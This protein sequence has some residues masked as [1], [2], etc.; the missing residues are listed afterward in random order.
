MF[1]RLF[2]RNG[3]K[4]GYDGLTH[5]FPTGLT[6]WQVWVA[7]G[8]NEYSQRDKLNLYACFQIYMIRSRGIDQMLLY[9]GGFKPNMLL[10]DP[11]KMFLGGYNQ[12]L[13]I[14]RIVSSA[15]NISCNKSSEL[16]DLIAKMGQV[17]RSY[18]SIKGIL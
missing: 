17:T 4:Y 1:S 6:L 10:V 7:K 9:L 5:Q 8:S 2:C 3:G 12:M 11:Q 16:G 14:L 13:M 18:S 15:D